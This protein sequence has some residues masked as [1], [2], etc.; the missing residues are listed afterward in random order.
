MKSREKSRMVAKEAN[1]EEKEDE[2]GEENDD[3]ERALSTSFLFLER[4]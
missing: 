4:K 1:E 3:E 2:E